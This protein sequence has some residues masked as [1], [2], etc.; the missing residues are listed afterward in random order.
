MIYK[1]FFRISLFLKQI[2]FS[3]KMLF[4]CYEQTLASSH[5]NLKQYYIVHIDAGLKR[6]EVW[7]CKTWSTGSQA[8]PHTGAEADQGFLPCVVQSLRDSPS[9]PGRPGC[10]LPTRQRRSSSRDTVDFVVLPS[11]PGWV[12]HCR[13]RPWGTP[14]LHHPVGQEQTLGELEN[15]RRMVELEALTI[16]IM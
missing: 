16:V 12:R 7:K 13:R 10:R 2:C 15:E 8:L 14:D 6:K 3:N 9:T 11:V 4:T 1:T 5:I